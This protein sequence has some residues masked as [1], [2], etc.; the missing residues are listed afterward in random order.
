MEVFLGVDIGG[1][2]VKFGAV[3]EDGVLLAKEKIKTSELHDKGS[4][5]VNFFNA[6]EKKLAEFPYIQKVGIGVPGT[7]TKDR[8]FTLE[9]PNLPKLSYIPLHDRLSEAFPHVTF[10]LEND[11]NAAA[12]GELVFS[13]QTLPDNFVLITLGTGVGAGAI[14]NRRIYLG[15]DGNALEIGHILASNGKTIEQNIGKKGIVEMMLNE[16]KKDEIKT[17]LN[18]NSSYK[19]IEKALHE[20]DKLAIK[21][22]REVGKYV[23]E[24]IIALARILD[25]KNFLIGGG[26]ADNW[27]YVFPS[28]IESCHQHLSPYYLK[29][30]KIIRA[31]LGNDA[32]MMGAAALVK[33]LNV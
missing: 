23:G 27:E 22:Y 3:R 25:I 18:K 7:L 24:A 13:R 31:T 9:Y 20:K 2:N 8:R 32:G 28:I 11:A 30:L 21:L 33:H 19:D 12:I 14:I 5:V 26:V 10:C 16:L 17:S 1:T 4:F 6:L 29:D 15:G